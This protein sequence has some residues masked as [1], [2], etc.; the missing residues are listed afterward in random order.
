MTRLPVDL[1]TRPPSPLF[2]F[3]SVLVANRRPLGWP[4]TRIS[5][6][7]LTFT[8]CPPDTGAALRLEGLAACVTELPAVRR[9]ERAAGDAVVESGGAGRRPAERR[10]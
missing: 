7:D 4:D 10:S 1:P 8:S 3:E 6:R 2:R 5:D 9:A